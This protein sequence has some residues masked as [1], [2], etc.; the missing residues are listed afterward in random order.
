MNKKPHIKMPSWS[1]LLCIW[2]VST[3]L[4]YGLESWKKNKGWIR[5]KIVGS[6]VRTYTAPSRAS[7]S[8]TILEGLDAKRLF[9]L[10]ELN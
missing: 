5:G 4:W 7:D 10:F 9:E 1:L 2:N 6:V 8:V 3:V